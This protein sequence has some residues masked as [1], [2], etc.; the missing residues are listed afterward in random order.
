MNKKLGRVLYSHVWVYFVV[1]A[2]FAAASFAMNQYLL[3]G[4]EAVATVVAVVTYILHKRSRNWE[5]QKFL[6]KLTDE[7]KALITKCV[8]NIISIRENYSDKTLSALYHKDKMP[9]DL[10]LAHSMLDEVI[11]KCYRSEPFL[12]NEDRLSVLFE[13]YERLEG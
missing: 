4:I 11:D 1:M 12:T 13:L 10:R 3:A 2:G 5:I 7:Q 9:E 8:Y 6:A